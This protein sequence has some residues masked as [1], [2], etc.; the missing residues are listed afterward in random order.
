MADNDNKFLD[1]DGVSYFWSKI[2]EKYTD[3][4]TLNS[5]IEKIKCPDFLPEDEGEVLQIVNG[6]KIWAPPPAAEVI[7]DEF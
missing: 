4:N 7:W 5:I 1:Q 2:M 6:E 3:T